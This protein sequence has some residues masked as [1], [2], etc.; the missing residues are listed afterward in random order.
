MSTQPY[1][2]LAE[3]KATHSN[4]DEV[5]AGLAALVSSTLEERGCFGFEIRAHASKEGHFFLWES[6]T[7]KAALTEHFEA[8]HTKAFLGKQ[9]TEVVEVQE[10][11]P[12]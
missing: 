6:W 9:W 3:I 12:L 8:T 1:Q 5:R 10:L 7:S 11:T 2:L 4:L